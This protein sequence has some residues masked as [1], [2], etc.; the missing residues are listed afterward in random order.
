MMH[1]A[2]SKRPVTLQIVTQ[3]QDMAE[4]PRGAHEQENLL[5]TTSG[6]FV[7]QMDVS[8]DM[9]GVARQWLQAGV[10][11]SKLHLESTMA[12]DPP[13][14]RAHTSSFI[15]RHAESGRFL[16]GSD[17]SVNNHVNTVRHQLRL[18][19]MI[20]R[21]QMKSVVMEDTDLLFLTAKYWNPYEIKREEV[22]GFGPDG[23]FELGNLPSIGVDLRCS[24]LRVENIHGALGLFC[25]SSRGARGLKELT[26]HVIWDHGWRWEDAISFLDKDLHIRLMLPHVLQDGFVNVR[27]FDCC[28]SMRVH[29]PNRKWTGMDGTPL[30]S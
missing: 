9:D 3:A 16:V 24:G 23:S 8:H 12:D 14:R 20:W 18:A 25:G 19:E 10:T 1:K 6:V 13:S 15:L 27:L 5:E 4:V 30:R 26:S 7:S 11:R 22:T 2:A 28:C 17:F 21:R 29:R